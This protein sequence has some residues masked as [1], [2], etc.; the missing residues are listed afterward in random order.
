MI[1][2]LDTYSFKSSV[3]LS[4]GRDD[5]VEAATLSVAAGQ[6]KPAKPNKLYNT[7]VH[8]CLNHLSIGN[9]H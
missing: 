6:I 3:H 8:F 9:D 7:T 4:V 1:E 5:D 2:T